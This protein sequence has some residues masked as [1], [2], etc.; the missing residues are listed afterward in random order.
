[1]DDA[2]TIFFLNFFP[3][4]FRFVFA[5]TISLSGSIGDSEN[6]NL[7]L[8][9]HKYTDPWGLVIQ[10]LICNFFLAF[11]GPVLY[12]CANC[13]GGHIFPMFI[14]SRNYMLGE[15]YAASRINGSI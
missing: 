13:P 9:E 15:L 10:N 8:E 3:T 2:Q 14:F 11:S 7:P 5:R 6:Q 12:Y 4:I 1:M